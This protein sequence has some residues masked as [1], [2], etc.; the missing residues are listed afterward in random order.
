MST[1]QAR[2]Q[3]NFHKV[4][5]QTRVREPLARDDPLVPR[6]AGKILAF[7]EAEGA[8]DTK[9]NGHAGK[10]AQTLANIGCRSSKPCHSWREPS[11]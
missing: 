4:T 6:A 7:M 1:Q 10:S 9:E 8:Q 11:R 3:S 5:A 2:S